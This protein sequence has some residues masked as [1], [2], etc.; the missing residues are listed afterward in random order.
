MCAAE[1]RRVTCAT[2]GTERTSELASMSE[3]P[4][5]PKCGDTGIQTPMTIAE[6]SVGIVDS[7]KP[8]LGP[9]EQERTWKRRWQDAQAHLD[10][11]LAP[12]SEP[13]DA[14]AIHAA[15]EGLQAFYV[16]T[17]HIKDSLKNA[18][19]TTSV[20]G[21]TVEDEISNNPDLALLADL[22]N[23]DKH[24]QLTRQI[25]SGHV[26]KIASVRGSP[27]SDGSASGG[28]RLDV[29]IEHKGRR[30]DGLDVAER[31]VSAWRQALERWDL[32]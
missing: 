11:L 17:Y 5:C 27:F 25:R 18:S 28:W 14:N 2:C 24:G 8:S 22:A 13:L 31:A 23:L 4:R 32:L 20:S 12:R 19:A 29:V 1:S 16:Q 30:L 26:P 9:A 21:Q 6:E 10:R 7:I 3:R 15:N